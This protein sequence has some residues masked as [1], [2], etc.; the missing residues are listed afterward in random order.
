MVSESGGLEFKPR[1]RILLRVIISSYRSSYGGA[2]VVQASG[3][4]MPERSGHGWHAVG[5]MLEPDKMSLAPSL[6]PEFYSWT[7][8]GGP[9][10]WYL[11]QEVSSSSP[12]HIYS[13]ARN[14]SY[15]QKSIQW[16]PRRT[17]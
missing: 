9:P 1:S 13:V 6:S 7:S 3:L 10:S 16:G 4:Y 14:Y 15:L 12:G 11:S 2:H 17:Y 8:R 5:R